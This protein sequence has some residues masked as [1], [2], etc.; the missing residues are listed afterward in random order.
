[1]KKGGSGTTNTFQA[2]SKGEARLVGLGLG[3]EASIKSVCLHIELSIMNLEIWTEKFLVRSQ[4]FLKLWKNLEL[5]M[6]FLCI[7]MFSV[8]VILQMCSLHFF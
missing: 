4:I 7:A 6:S 3:M 5:K 8:K 1:M 2:V